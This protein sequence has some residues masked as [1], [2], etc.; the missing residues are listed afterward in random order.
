[1]SYAVLDQSEHLLVG[2]HEE[3]REV[4]LQHIDVDYNE[5]TE[6]RAE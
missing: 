1:M 2:R 3:Q 6:E 4:V 5:R